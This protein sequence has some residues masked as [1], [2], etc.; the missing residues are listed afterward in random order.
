M[1]T[2]LFDRVAQF[3]CPVQRVY[4]NLYPEPGSLRV[5]IVDMNTK[6]APFFPIHPL[7]SACLRPRILPDRSNLDLRF[8]SSTFLLYAM[9]GSGARSRTPTDRGQSERVWCEKCLG[10]FGI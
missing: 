7:Q 1:C 2:Q 8:F 6:S 5:G 9:R 3:V 10:K 4:G